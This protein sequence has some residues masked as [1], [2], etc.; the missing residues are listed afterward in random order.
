MRNLTRWEVR[1]SGE[2][3]G[4]PF[5]GPA[6]GKYQDPVSA[7]IDAVSG[8]PA[9]LL[10]AGASL[11]SGLI[12][13]GASKSAADTQANAANNATNAQLSMFNTI[14]SQQQPYRDAGYSSLNTIQ[15][16]LPKF[17]HSFDT[18]DLNSNLAPNYQWALNQGLGAVKNAGNAQTGLLS[19]NTLKGIADYA[20]NAA[21]N[22]YQQAFNNYN[23]NQT[24][25][26]NRLSNLAGLGQTANANAGQAGTALAGNAGNSM[27]A[28]GQ[29]QGSGTVGA[30][31]ALSGG[32]N[33]A[34]GWY[35]LPQIMNMGGNSTASL[36]NQYGA[37]NVF[38]PS[39]GG[40]V[41]SQITNWDA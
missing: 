20:T 21:G 32:L 35:A 11:A 27:I 25:I 19:G 29:A 14:N 30:A 40:S 7:V 15:S 39:G 18:N 24:N 31:N 12:G 26:Y 5:G 38:T 16:M 37:G 23:A 41:P 17:T 10:G 28:A 13:A 8:A 6:Y 2:P 33:N 1:N 34:F 9:S 36:V 4:D 3:I 22:A